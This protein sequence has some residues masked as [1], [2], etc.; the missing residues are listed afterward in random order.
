[1]SRLSLICV[2]SALF[3]AACDTGSAPDTQRPA[4]IGGDTGSAEAPKAPPPLPGKIVRAQAGTPLP[5]LTFK[6]PDGNTLALADLKGKPVLINLW[7]TWCVP[8]RKEMPLL[9][10][11]ADELGEDVKV[12]T[13]SQDRETRQPEVIAFFAEGNFRN[14]EQWLDPEAA[15][16]AQFAKAGLPT[17]ILFDEEGREVFRVLGDYKWDSEDAI[18]AVREA[19]SK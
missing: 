4:E 19:V 10:N 5:D 18:A 17:T 1:M 15:L 11:L 8:C 2:A 7:A 14:L 3:L 16:T 13:V 9:D 12:L 6:D